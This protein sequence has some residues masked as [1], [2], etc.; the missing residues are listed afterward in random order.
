[1]KTHV[2]TKEFNGYS[3]GDEVD[4]REWLNTD[5]LERC[6]YLERKESAKER[7]AKLKGE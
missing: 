6:R 7:I 2:V 1:M 3:I 4:A 5:K